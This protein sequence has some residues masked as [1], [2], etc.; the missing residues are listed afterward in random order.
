MGLLGTVFEFNG[1]VPSLNDFEQKIREL[2][3]ER[4]MREGTLDPETDDVLRAKENRP[5]GVTLLMRNSHATF[6]VEGDRTRWKR[7]VDLTVS[8]DGK[9]VSVTGNYQPLFKSACEAVTALGGHDYL[10]RKKRL[11][12]GTA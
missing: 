4:L 8:L 12:K 11:K 7:S 1:I 9:K 2:S 10:A 3:S 6:W 5:A